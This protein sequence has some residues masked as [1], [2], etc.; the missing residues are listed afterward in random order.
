MAKQ[1]YKYKSSIGIRK[2]RKLFTLLSYV[3]FVNEINILHL[4]EYKI[5]CLVQV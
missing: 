1:N 5:Y 3:Q 4:I 2:Q